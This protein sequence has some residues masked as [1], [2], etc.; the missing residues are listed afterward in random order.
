MGLPLTVSLGCVPKKAIR[1]DTHLSSFRCGS[2]RGVAVCCFSIDFPQAIPTSTGTV[3][4]GHSTHPLGLALLSAKGHTTV[5][6]AKKFNR[7]TNWTDAPFREPISQKILRGPKEKG[8]R[9]DKELSHHHKQYNHMMKQHIFLLSVIVLLAQVLFVGA[10]KSPTISYMETRP[11]RKTTSAWSFENEADISFDGDVA[12]IQAMALE[13]AA[14]LAQENESNNNSDKGGDD[15]DGNGDGQNQHATEAP[16]PSKGD[17]QSSSSNISMAVLG[18]MA[19]AAAFL[20]FVVGLFVWKRSSRK[21]G[22]ILLSDVGSSI[23]GLPSTSDDGDETEIEAP[24][25]PVIDMLPPAYQDQSNETMSI[26]SG[27]G[28]SAVTEV[29]EAEDSTRAGY[30]PQ[31]SDECKSSPSSLLIVGAGIPSSQP[32]RNPGPSYRQ[33]T[34]GEGGP[35]YD[36]D[37]SDVSDSPKAE[38][39]GFSEALESLLLGT[40]TPLQTRT[41]E[42]DEDLLFLA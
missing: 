25:S 18:T 1:F 16:A 17:E 20:V 11:R 31:Q 10:R 41:A 4:K 2:S 32:Q 21:G 9:K 34:D 38:S 22:A 12:A 40:S 5:K 36:D 14:L 23:Q 15:T 13:K 6:T 39:N 33:D 28:L 27:L 35:Q 19:A 30:S 8:R 24:E 37:V 7:G 3:D 42:E 26:F 29:T